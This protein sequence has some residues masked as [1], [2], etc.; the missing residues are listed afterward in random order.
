MSRLKSVSALFGTAFWV[1]GLFFAGPASAHH[2]VLAVYDVNKLITVTG[3]VAKVEWISPHSFITVNVKDADGNV[4][5]WAFETGYGALRKAGM[6][7]ADRGGIKPGDEIVI[8]AAP[9]KDGS[10]NGYLRELKLG[11][12]RVFKFGA[13]ENGN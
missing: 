10:T 9:A 1:L 8:S 11:D 7:R 2:S 13:D 12:G 6:S 5:K 4:K 3:T